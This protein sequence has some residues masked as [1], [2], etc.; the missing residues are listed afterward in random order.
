M[1]DGTVSSDEQSR[2]RRYLS[3]GGSSGNALIGVP[4]KVSSSKHTISL[5]DNGSSLIGVPSKVSFFKHTISLIDNGSSLMP[6]L[7]KLSS[8]KDF[9]GTVI[10]GKL[11][12]FEQP[13]ISNERS[14]VRNWIDEGSSLSGVPSNFRIF[15][16][17]ICLNDIEGISLM[18]VLLKI[19]CSKDSISTVISGK[20]SSFEQPLI[21]NLWSLVRNWIDEGSSLSGV[22]LKLRLCKDSIG[23]V[24]S[25]KLSSFEQP[26]ISND[27]SLVRNWI[28]EGSSLS[29]VLLKLRL[30]KD[31]IGTVI[32]GKLSSFEQP[33]ISNDW[34][35]VR[36]WI[37]EGSS[38]SGVLLKLRL[39]KDFIGT[40]IS[41]KLS[42]FEQPLISNDWSLV[43][44]WI[45]EG[46]SLSG[47]P[48]KFRIFKA[49]ICSNDMEGISL[50]PVS[51]KIRR[52]K[53]FIGTVISG[54]L[55]IFEQPLRERISNLPVIDCGTSLIEVI[56]K[57][58]YFRFC[59][60][61]GHVVTSRHRLIASTLRTFE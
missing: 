46:S 52:R 18:P 60:I 11:S 41:G 32:S 27:W 23:T 14:L 44:N 22:L 45:D 37:D 58:K 30:C 12:S 3:E 36:N 2:V 4:C 16:D 42:S 1:I 59:E 49:G 61:V 15:K 38:L 19:R 21:S 54:N 7:L 17:V 20:L 26:L 24:I 6:V 55:V 5:I 28:D 34:S 48:S 43:R 53:D 56:S 40:V 33:L 29:G 8:T 13:L 57:R 10:S 50:M 51:L 47:V 39:C 31:F 9:I 25:G 35:L